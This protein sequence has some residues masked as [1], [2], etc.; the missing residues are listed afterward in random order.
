MTTKFPTNFLHHLQLLHCN[1]Q[2]LQPLHQAH[3]LAKLIQKTGG[4]LEICIHNYQ[5]VSFQLPTSTNLHVHIAYVSHIIYSQFH[6]SYV[7]TSLILY[8]TFSHSFSMS[9]RIIGRVYDGQS[10]RPKLQYKQHARSPPVR[11]RQHLIY[12]VS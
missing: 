11:M 12:C 7:L 9:Y 10:I 4:A 1:L 3:H 2:I 8:F 5:Y 6:A